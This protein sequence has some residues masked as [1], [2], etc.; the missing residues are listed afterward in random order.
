[1]P[2]TISTQ[3]IKVAVEQRNMMPAEDIAE[4]RSAVTIVLTF[5]DLLPRSANKKRVV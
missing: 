1:M 3:P 5:S 4:L 2:R